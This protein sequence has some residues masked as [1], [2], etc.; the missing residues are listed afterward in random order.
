MET[1]QKYFVH[2]VHADDI[3]NFELKAYMLCVTSEPLAQTPRLTV[4][5]LHDAT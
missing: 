5:F 2:M 1:W 4:I 3:F